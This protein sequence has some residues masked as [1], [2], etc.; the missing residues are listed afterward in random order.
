MFVLMRPM[1]QI[2]TALGRYSETRKPRWLRPRSE[3]FQEVQVQGRHL[4][5]R[6]VMRYIMVC[7]ARVDHCKAEKQ[8]RSSSSDDI[9]LQSAL[10]I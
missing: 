9:A 6:A 5:S 10:G 1:Y 8:S 2:G 3:K 7:G 4:S